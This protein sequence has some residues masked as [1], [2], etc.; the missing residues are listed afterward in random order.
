MGGPDYQQESLQYMFDVLLKKLGKGTH[1]TYTSGWKRWVWFCR[2]RERNPYLR[3]KGTEGELA[4]EEQ[5]LLEFASHQAKWLHRA[6]GTIRSKLLAVKFYHL[7]AGLP[8]PLGNRPR[9]WMLVEGIQRHMG[10]TVRKKFTKS[11]HLRWALW[12]Y[13]HASNDEFV[14]FAALVVGWF[15]LLRGGE[16]CLNPSSPWQLDRVVRGSDLKPQ[17]D[18]L[19]VERF[20]DADEVVLNLRGIKVDQTNE[21]Q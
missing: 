15:F 6:A 13:W 2:A 11:E 10:A 1:S 21:G 16:Y 5:R 12:R 17:A 19:A 9:V 4:E 3:G 7:V 8:D 14:V 18:G 20:E